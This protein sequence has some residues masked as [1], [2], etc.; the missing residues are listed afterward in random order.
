[1]LEKYTNIYYRCK[2]I[3]ENINAPWSHPTLQLI[4]ND[5][6]NAPTTISDE[7]LNK[8]IFNITSS[9]IDKNDHNYFNS[10]FPSTEL[11]YF[12]I[13]RGCMIEMRARKLIETKCDRLAMN[14]VTEALR[15]IRL[16]NDEHILRKTVS[17][18]QHQTLYEIY[19][20]LMYKF[21]DSSRLKA[22]LEAMDLEQV[23][24]FIVN[25]FASIDAHVALTKK[26][27]KKQQQQQP[28]PSQQQTGKRKEQLSATARLHKYHVAVSQY[29]LQLILVRILSGEYTTDCLDY[30]FRRLLIEWIRR[31][32]EVQNFDELFQKLIQTAATN[33]R[34]YDCC[35]I[36]YEMV[37]THG[38]GIF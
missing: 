12:S 19:F 31:N 9:S 17:L 18:G 13:E 29:A 24:D 2:Y 28:S 32:K 3:V 30:A 20:S 15:I 38:T 1:M 35:E 21:K 14:F 25:S 22:E 34:I 16:C 7:Q 33:A 10:I 4:F 37:G 27:V 26:L 23:V 36:L 5:G 8:G 11:E 6:Q